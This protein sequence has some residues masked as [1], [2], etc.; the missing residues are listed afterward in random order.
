MPEADFDFISKIDGNGVRNSIKGWRLQRK[1]NSERYRINPFLE[2]IDLYI[3][4][5]QAFPLQTI[6]ILTEFIFR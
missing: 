3:D 5:N 2:P 6:T 4:V 1:A